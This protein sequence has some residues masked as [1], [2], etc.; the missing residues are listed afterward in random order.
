MDEK[1]KMTE[2]EKCCQWWSNLPTRI[3]NTW[4]RRKVAHLAFMEGYR[5]GLAAALEG[6]TY[7]I[8]LDQRVQDTIS[9]SG[10]YLNPID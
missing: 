9:R 2:E 7:E 10:P 6:R 1:V 4:S 5:Q 3:T 8:E